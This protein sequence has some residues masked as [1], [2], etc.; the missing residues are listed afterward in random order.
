MSLFLCYT[1]PN[2]FFLYLVIYDN[3]KQKMA[4]TAA[5]ITYAALVGSAVG[6]SAFFMI[7]G[8]PEGTKVDDARVEPIEVA[9]TETSYTLDDPHL[10]PH[11]ISSENFKPSNEFG[12]DPLGVKQYKRTDIFKAG[13]VE[14]GG[15]LKSKRRSRKHR[16]RRALSS[17][18]HR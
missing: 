12:Y 14:I 8:T 11:S 17:S 3:I 13:P 5:N 6:L 4:L 10:T 18:K 1:L 9:H 16:K 15:R 7:G 2:Q